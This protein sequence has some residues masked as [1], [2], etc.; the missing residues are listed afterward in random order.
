[1]TPRLDRRRVPA[2]TVS[3]DA[4]ST[5][6][7]LVFAEPPLPRLCKTR[8][9]VWQREPSFYQTEQYRTR[10]KNKRWTCELVT[11]WNGTHWMSAFN[12]VSH[13]QFDWKEATTR[14]LNKTLRNYNGYSELTTHPARPT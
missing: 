14:Q 13:T 8:I 9:Q 4:T 7:K 5:H 10:R 6:V 11:Y 3:S 12:S 1:M 2:V